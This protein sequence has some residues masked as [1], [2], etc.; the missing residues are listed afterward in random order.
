MKAEGKVAQRQSITGT[1]SYAKKLGTLPYRKLPFNPIGRH[2]KT[3][4]RR[5]AG[6]D[7][8]FYN[9]VMASKWI[10]RGEEAT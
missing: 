1:V 3:I 9:E 8:S 10:G 5:V 4:S 7:F 6:W 2:E